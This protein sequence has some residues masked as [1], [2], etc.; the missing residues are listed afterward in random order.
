MRPMRKHLVACLFVFGVGAAA[1]G[2]GGSDTSNNGGGTVDSGV[3]TSVSP[4]AVCGDGICSASEA[5]SCTQDCGSGGNGSGSGTADAGTTQ[6]VC[7]D[8][9]CDAQAGE[10][11]ATCPGDCPTGGGGSAFCMD[12]NTIIGCFCDFIDPTTCVA[13]Y[14]VQACM[15]CGF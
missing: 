6:A 15:D 13:P 5:N 4:P 12:Q 2:C 3:S 11:N 9:I 8:T 7:G 1:Y 14:T 10:T